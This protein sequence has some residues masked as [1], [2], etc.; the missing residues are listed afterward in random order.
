[1]P[2]AG[3]A[4]VAL[5]VAI[6]GHLKVNLKEKMYLNV[7]STTERCQKKIIKT[8]LIKVFFLFTASIN[9]TGGAT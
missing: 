7:N 2:G 6:K 5:P 9:D 1:L 3:T 8:F 4:G